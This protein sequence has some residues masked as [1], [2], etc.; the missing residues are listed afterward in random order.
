MRNIGVAVVCGVLLAGDLGAGIAGA[1]QVQ[2][3][4]TNRTIAVTTSETAER[5]ADTA[6]VHIGYQLYGPTSEAVTEAAARASKAIVAA[7][8]Q[9]GVADDAIESEQ[10]STGPVQNYQENGLS[11]AEKEDRKFQAQQSWQVKAPAD[12]AAKL[13]AAAVAAGANQSGSIDW[14]VADEAS[15]S[16]EAAAKALKHAREIAQQMAQGLDAKVGM[17]LY[18]SNQADQV[19]VMPMMAREGLVGAMAKGAP[20]SH[21]LSL[22]PPMV[23]R[24]ATVSAVFAIE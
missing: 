21:T 16:A 13:L 12:D 10:Q 24:S 3:S 11:P 17:L 19:R 15:L 2:V 6:T 9:L 4:P 23:S 7:E 22:S 14:S 8:K 20:V 18:A 5:R 1:Q